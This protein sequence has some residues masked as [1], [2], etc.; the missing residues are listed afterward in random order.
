MVYVRWLLSFSVLFAGAATLGL[1]DAME[2]WPRLL[3]WA[4]T[5]PFVLGAYALIHPEIVR[6]RRPR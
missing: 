4:L 2:E 5:V 1:L 3:A 6:H